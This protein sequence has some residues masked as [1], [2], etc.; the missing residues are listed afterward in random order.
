MGPGSRTPLGPAVQS[1]LHQHAGQKTTPDQCQTIKFLLQQ[2]E[3]ST[4][5]FAQTCL[6]CSKVYCRVDLRRSALRRRGQKSDVRRV[7]PSGRNQ[8]G[9]SGARSAIGQTV[10][11]VSE[12][13]AADLT[14]VG[15]LL[16]DSRNQTF[17]ILL[18]RQDCAQLVQL[19]K[20]GQRS[21]IPAQRRHNGLHIG[22]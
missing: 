9:P 8:S 5:T 13:A 10:P 4:E 6:P 11:L 22:M 20:V 1:R 15:R 3:P 17:A 12:T 14:V 18:R 21:R 2:R 19:F 7:A 16:S